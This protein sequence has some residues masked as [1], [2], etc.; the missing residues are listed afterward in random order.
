MIVISKFEFAMRRLCFIGAVAAVALTHTTILH[1]QDAVLMINNASDGSNKCLIFGAN[2]TEKF[3]SRY[4]WGHGNAFCGFPGGEPALIANKQAIW[5]AVLLEGDKYMLKNASDGTDKCLI[6][7]GNGTEKFP[8]R[9]D[10]GHGN[11]F[12]GFPGG[13][14]ALLANKQAVWRMVLLEGNKYMLKNASDGS[15]KCLIFG[16]NGTEKF[17]SRYDWGHGNAFCGFPGGKD[18]LLA[19]KQAVF[20]TTP[21]AAP[22]NAVTV[23]GCAQPG[24]ESGCVIM[25]SGDQTYIISGANPAPAW[26]HWIRVTGKPG[27]A[28]T[29]QQGT[30][31]SDITWTY[32]HNPQACPPR[33]PSLWDPGPPYNP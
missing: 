23:T 19:N 31:L 25:K 5:R 7:G 3:P 26:D 24:V 2:G 32:V 13:K 14:D 20:E 28:S 22:G 4:D 17:P 30:Q 9:Y 21:V 10:W 18:A 33:P 29:C 6:F 8:S 15:D 16:G 11:T 12:C 1:A 27:G